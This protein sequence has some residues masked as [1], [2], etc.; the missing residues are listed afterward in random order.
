MMTRGPEIATD[1]PKP[2][3]PLTLMEVYV[4]EAVHVD[5]AVQAITC[6]RPLHDVPTLGA[7]TTSRVEDMASA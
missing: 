7:P 2:T 3:M 5:A 1:V 4:F 6:T